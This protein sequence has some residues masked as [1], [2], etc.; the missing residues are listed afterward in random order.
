[1][2]ITVNNALRKY[3]HH[4]TLSHIHTK[5]NQLSGCNFFFSAPEDSANHTGSRPKTVIK[6]KKKRKKNLTLYLFIFIFTNKQ[7]STSPK[8]V[9]VGSRNVFSI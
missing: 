4:T 7:L 5:P 2:P 9:S 3:V 8:N 6:K 1:M